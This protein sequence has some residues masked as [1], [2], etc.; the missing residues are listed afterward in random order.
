MYFCPDLPDVQPA[1]FAGLT[2]CSV[3]QEKPDSNVAASR[4]TPEHHKTGLAE[5]SS[6][7]PTSSVR[8]PTIHQQHDERDR[9][10]R[11]GWGETYLSH[12]SL[13]TSLIADVMLDLSDD[14]IGSI[15]HLRLDCEPQGFGD[16]QVDG[17][18][19]LLVHLD[20]DLRRLRP[21]EDLVYQEC[22]LP[23]RFVQ[24][25]GI[26]GECAALYPER[27]TEY[28]RDCLLGGRL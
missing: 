28:G 19:D 13:G 24:I 10:L 18:L 2:N 21:F 27:S 3:F 16:F 25:W 1:I 26:A 14:S 17:E 12:L 4:N 8:S 7:V 5:C 20:G 9:P 6:S 15:Q 23:S 22:R 11:V